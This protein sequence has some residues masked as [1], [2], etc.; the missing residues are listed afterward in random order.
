MTLYIIPGHIVTAFASAPATSED[1]LRVRSVEEVEGSGLSAAQ[2]VAIWNALPGAKTL[3]KF[4][5]RK[6]AAQRLWAAFGKLP[7]AA[8]FAAAGA[9]GSRPGSKQAQVIGLLQQ[10]EG[11]TIDEMASAMGWQ[12][13]T[14]RGLISGALKKKLG[15]DIQTEK[16]DRGRCYRIG[17]SRPAAQ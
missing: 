4:K 7:V 13:H 16:T 5:N 10:P 9:S 11:A 8:E 2:M 15:L 1:E 14:V 17:E 6:T 3:S 12:R